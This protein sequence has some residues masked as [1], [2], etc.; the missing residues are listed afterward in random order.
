MS[1][2]KIEEMARDLS[3]MIGNSPKLQAEKLYAKGYRKQSEP[4]SRGHENGG[5]WILCERL[6][7]YEVDTWKCSQ[8]QTF[9]RDDEKRKMKFCPNCGAKMKG[10]E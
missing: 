7:D 10:G 6:Y 2:E 4:F 1:R 8:C 9:I 3:E 5:E